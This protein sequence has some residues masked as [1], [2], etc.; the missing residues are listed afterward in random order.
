MKAI[1]WISHM[2]CQRCSEA[3]SS[4]R[5]WSGYLIDYTTFLLEEPSKAQGI[6]QSL[7]LFHSAIEY[8]NVRLGSL[9]T[10]LL[11]EDERKVYKVGY[12]WTFHLVK[13]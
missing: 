12:L 4:R 13:K 6:L 1:S 7:L 11:T 3:L 9:A 5:K 10:A 2:C 8:L